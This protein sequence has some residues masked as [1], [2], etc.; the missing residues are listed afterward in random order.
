MKDT[1]RSYAPKYYEVN[2]DALYPSCANVFRYYLGERDDLETLLNYLCAKRKENNLY[3]MLYD[4][5][6]NDKDNGIARE[7]KVLAL[8]SDILIDEFRL[9]WVNNSQYLFKGIHAKIVV[10]KDRNGYDSKYVFFDSIDEFML[11][12]PNGRAK[13][14]PKLDCDFIAVPDRSEKCATLKPLL[15]YNEVKSEY[16]GNDFSYPLIDASVFR[17]IIYDLDLLRY[18]S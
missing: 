14:L 15:G 13:T 8:A 12:G 5:L 17:Q 6:R 16:A 3:M 7:A 9:L 4:Y 18:R 10:T 2:I 1:L 11:V